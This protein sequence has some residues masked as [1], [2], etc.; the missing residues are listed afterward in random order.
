MSVNEFAQ[1][2]RDGL[3][4]AQRYIHPKWHYDERGSELFVQIT[5]EPEYYLT[6]TEK[7]I[8]KKNAQY[9]IGNT[10]ENVHIIE[11]GAGE[12]PSKVAY[13][14]NAALKDSCRSVEYTGIDINDNA[15]SAL[16]ARYGQYSQLAISSINAQYIEGLER[17]PTSSNKKI[18]LFLGS[19]IGNLTR[20]EEKEF[21][22]ELR[23]RMSP[24]DAVLIGFD[25]VK[26]EGIL[27]AAYNDK[28]GTTEMFSLNLLR[29]I[30]TELDGNFNLRDFKHE[31]AYDDEKQSVESFLVSQKK[32][33][34]YVNAIG[35]G[36][37][38]CEGEKIHVERSRKYTCED[39]KA[40]QVLLEAPGLMLF[41]DDEAQFFNALFK[42]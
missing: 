32:Q 23:K 11:L 12:D 2:I 21:L 34:V 42:I 22:L 19:S 5:E 29:R 4:A 14:L 25:S 37:D 10:G 16:I 38:L 3:T 26:N 15:C 31:A 35:L 17:I 6:R 27:N 30:N 40:I 33:Q 7:G 8:L 20:K 18:V 1:S 9:I 13:L 28:S 41:M 24:G 39:I 36:I